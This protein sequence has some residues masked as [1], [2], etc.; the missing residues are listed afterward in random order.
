PV[1]RANTPTPHGSAWDSVPDKNNGPR[2][3]RGVSRLHSRVW[4]ASLREAP[5]HREVR[6]GG[7]RPERRGR[8]PGR[9]ETPLHVRAIATGV[10]VQSSG[11]CAPI[12]ACPQSQASYVLTS[13]HTEAMV[14]ALAAAL[15]PPLHRWIRRPRREVTRRCIVGA[16]QP[17][18]ET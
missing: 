6:I 7:P 2:R 14:A 16:A 9:R 12:G 8:H 11:S 3:G 18:T 13:D 15:C 10:R 5:F 1:W 4:P 17:R